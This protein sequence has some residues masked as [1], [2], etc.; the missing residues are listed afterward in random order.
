MCGHLAT[1]KTWQECL[2]NIVL[3]GL[4]LGGVNGHDLSLAGLMGINEHRI[5]YIQHGSE[6]WWHAGF[7]LLKA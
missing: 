3:N 4:H 1:T 6:S 2:Y 7:S 5:N